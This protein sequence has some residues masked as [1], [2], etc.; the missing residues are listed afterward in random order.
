MVIANKF[1]DSHLPNLRDVTM[2]HINYYWSFHTQLRYDSIHHHEYQAIAVMYNWYL[3][4]KIS[5]LMGIA[6]GLMYLYNE[7]YQYY[8]NYDL[9]TS[10]MLVY[11]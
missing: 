4:D 6:L 1:N 2:K 7:C 5:I 10:K 9:I 8:G 3:A 11:F